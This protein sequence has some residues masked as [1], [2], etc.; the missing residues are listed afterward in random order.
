M[1]AVRRN[2]NLSNSELAITVGVVVDSMNRDSTELAVRGVTQTNIDDFE[3]LGNAFEIFPTDDIYKAEISIVAEEK[4]NSRNICY[5]KI[6][7]ISGYFEQNWGLNS[8][9][10][11]QLGIRYLSDMRDG[12]FLVAAR[13]VVQVST[14]RLSDLTP[15]GLTQT[16]I[17][18]LDAEAQIFEDKIH[19]IYSKTAEREIKTQER[20][21]LANSLY[22]ELKKYS[23]IGKLVWENVDEAKYNDYVIHKTVHSGLPKPQGLSSEIDPVVPNQINITWNSVLDA[24]EY[25]LHGSQVPS[26]Q[27]AGEFSLINVVNLPQDIQIIDPGFTYY[28]K[29]RAKNTEK[30]S[31]YSDIISAEI[32]PTGP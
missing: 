32:T 4:T 31:D 24:T 11:K 15:I 25:E 14:T 19:A 5:D 26:G 8:P 29:V 12:D 21:N 10:Y 2:N 30:V 3:A 16:E 1:E 6:Q 9:Y 28:Y 20:T 27:P 13:R 23:T 17:D 22:N 7:R 18:D